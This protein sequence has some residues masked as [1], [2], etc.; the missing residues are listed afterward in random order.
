MTTESA[1]YRNV[2]IPGFWEET[3]LEAIDRQQWETL[4]D[5]CGKCCLFKVEDPTTAQVFYTNVAC[6]LFEQ[7]TC[8][9][10]AYSR[11]SELVPDCVTLTPETLSDPSWLPATC[12]YRLIAEDRALPSWHPLISGTQDTVVSSG[13]SVCGR[14]IAEAEADDLEHHLID[15]IY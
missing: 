1:D 5:G 4:C 10:T 12:A 15:W 7:Q 8:R 14:V 13:N 9:C 2:R 3:P 6:R 11:R